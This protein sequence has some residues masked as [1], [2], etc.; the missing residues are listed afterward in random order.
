M[1]YGGLRLESG[2][3]LRARRMHWFR[4]AAPPDERLPIESN[5]RQERRS[6]RPAVHHF[7]ASSADRVELWPENPNSWR[8]S[9]L[10]ESPTCA[11]VS[12]SRSG[13]SPIQ[14]PH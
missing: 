5:H 10:Q 4:L 6:A 14:S 7:K 12:P 9:V 1:A 11:E 13:E 2:Y 8:K 3:A